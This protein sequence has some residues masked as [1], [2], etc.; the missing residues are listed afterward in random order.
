MEAQG[1]GVTAAIAVLTARLG[2]GARRA[3]C[4][5]FT[6]DRFA[7]DLSRKKGM[8]EWLSRAVLV[9][10]IGVISGDLRKKAY[11]TPAQSKMT[12]NNAFIPIV[13]DAFILRRG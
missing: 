8:C 11:T 2:K 12:E 4:R 10:Q 5:M 7:V 1:R 13:C 9:A 3:P 6:A